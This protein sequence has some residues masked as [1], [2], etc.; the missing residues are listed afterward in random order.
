M[1]TTD[2]QSPANGAHLDHANPVKP[3]QQ[4]L[5]QVCEEWANNLKVVLFSEEQIQRKVAELADRINRDYAGKKPLCVGL[6]SGCFLFLADILRKLLVP[7]EVD[8]MVVS[9]YGHGTTSSGSVKLKKDMSIDPRGRDILI[10]EDLIDTGNTL[11]WI[12]RHLQTKG[13]SSIKLCVL[14]DKIERRTANVQVDY[15]GFQCPDEFVVGYG[16][17]YADQYRCMPFVAVLAPKAYGGSSE[18]KVMQT[19][20]SA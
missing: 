14:L 17:D 2:A 1:S 11:E 12:V 20:N 10:I 9:S 4:Q 7:Y 8:F 18:K 3:T 13:C 19:N 16:M 5:G 6:L 15:V